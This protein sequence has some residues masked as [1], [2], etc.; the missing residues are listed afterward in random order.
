MV[1]VFLIAALTLGV[2]GQAPSNS[3]NVPQNPIAMLEGE[4]A[5]PDL[6]P[7]TTFRFTCGWVGG[8]TR[9]MSCRQRTESKGRVMELLGVYSSRP[10][11]STHTLT[12]FLPNGQVW[13]YTGGM[14]G[15]RLVLNLV[16]Q[17]PDAPR[18]RLITIPSKDTIRFLEEVSENG[19]TWKLSAPSEDYTLVRV[20]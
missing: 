6:P 16:S 19:T 18:L 20:K 7:G 5:R 14:E 3:T 4:W 1:P 11:N 8:E 13:T 15:E 10:S 9:H 17:R 12:M 2:I